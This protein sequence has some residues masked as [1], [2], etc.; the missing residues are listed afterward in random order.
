MDFNDMLRLV[1]GGGPA[2][3]VMDAQASAP[4][5]PAQQAP[6]APPPNAPQGV[7]TPVTNPAPA[8]SAPTALQSP[9]DLANMYLELMRKSQNAHQLDSGLNLIAAG[10]SNSPTNRAALISASAGG[11]SG[12]MSLSANDLINFQ[13]QA[14]AN[15][16]SLIQ[17]Q[18]LPAL[19][20]QY[21]MT[22][23]QIQYL[24]S[25]GKLDEVLQNFATRSLA[26]ITDANGQVHLVD[27]RAEGGKGRVIAT[28]GSEKPED[29]LE[30]TRPDG[31]KILVKKETGEF[32]KELAPAAKPGD[33]IDPLQNQL[34]AINA[35]N[36]AAGKPPMTMPELIKLKQQP[37][38]SVNVSPSGATFP[39]PAEGYDYLRNPDNTVKVDADGKPMQYPIT[40]G[41]AAIEAAEK[42]KKEAQALTD[43]EK[44]EN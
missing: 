4:P 1:F 36:A 13:K 40:G 19:M 10:L 21:N 18:A 23:E 27:D 6:A 37:G 34:N 12:G 42:A 26:H 11:G 44:L 17:Q 38:V 25:T 8:S 5:A 32:V 15:R 16:Q 20:K 28:V 7:P 30:V 29:T 22:P 14:E 35:E 39:K 2:S 41:P 9:P 24:K 33:V 3:T 43:K 31:S